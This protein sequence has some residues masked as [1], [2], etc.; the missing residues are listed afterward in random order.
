MHQCSNEL[1]CL[2]RRR[3]VTSSRPGF[4]LGVSLHPAAIHLAQDERRAKRKEQPGQMCFQWDLAA[5]RPQRPQCGVAGVWHNNTVGTL[6][7]R[8]FGNLLSQGFRLTW[9]DRAN[10][11]T[12][13]HAGLCC[14][15]ADCWSLA[16]SALLKLLLVNTM[17]LIEHYDV[18]DMEIITLYS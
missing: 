7:G 6:E 11:I 3:Q 5:G 14:S 12:R 1:K 9:C 13:R 10:F 18:C 17:L 15:K 8:R 2:S 16:L 4:A